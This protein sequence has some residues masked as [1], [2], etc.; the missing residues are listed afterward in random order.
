MTSKVECLPATSDKDNQ[1]IGTITFIDKTIFHRDYV[2]L[3]IFNEISELM[4][5]V[6][7]VSY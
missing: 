2:K 6:K 5:L 1:F 7:K 4:I 3:Q